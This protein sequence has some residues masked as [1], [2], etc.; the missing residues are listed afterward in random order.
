MTDDVSKMVVEQRIRNRLMDYFEIA[1]S[2]AKQLNYQAKVP[3]VH[4]PNEMINQWE[5]WIR[6]DHL[7]DWYT[8]PVFSIPE[9]A[10]IRR[11]DAIWSN[12][13]DVMPDLPL[14]ELIKTQTWEKLRSAAE[15]ALKVF[16]VRGRFDDEREAFSQL[17]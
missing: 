6:R 15:E 5:D 10:A 17:P 8:E 13:A 9:Q 2:F 7:D 16:E 4:V 14:S 11:Y 1:S 3:F 12:V